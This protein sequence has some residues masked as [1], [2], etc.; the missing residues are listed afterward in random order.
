MCLYQLKDGLEGPSLKFAQVGQEVTHLWH[1]DDSVSLVYGILIH[2]CFADDGQGNKFQL[3]DDRGCSTDPW[4]LPQIQYQ[5]NKISAFTN[6]QVFKYADKIQLFFSCTIQLCYKH[7]GGC[8][9]ITPPKCGTSQSDVLRTSA[10]LTAP[11]DTSFKIPTNENIP[12]IVPQN[13][14]LVHPSQNSELGPKLDRPKL[15]FFSPTHPHT[16]HKNTPE[17][18]LGRSEYPSQEP[19]KEPIPNRAFFG[20]MPGTSI[21]NQIRSRNEKETDFLQTPYKDSPINETDSDDIQTSQQAAWM[22]KNIISAK[23]SVMEIKEPVSPPRLTRQFKPN[24][25][26]SNPKLESVY[27]NKTASHASGERLTK[28]RRDLDMETD[29]HV[30]VIVLPFEDKKQDIMAAFDLTKRM[31]PFFDLHL[32]IPLLE[33]IEPRKVDPVIEILERD[34][35]KELM[36]NTRERDGNNRILE[37]LQQNHNVGMT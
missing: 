27:I 15:D 2:S 9:E 13:T 11:S 1:C 10:D 28:K 34:D 17:G 32:I 4:L 12:N 24:I 23:L 33:F 18:Q 25:T 20:P 26:I 21:S 19:F 31:A 3:V 22:T 35:V 37:F 29:L 6:T 30:D 8:E 5:A 7:D 36:E 14:L 16:K